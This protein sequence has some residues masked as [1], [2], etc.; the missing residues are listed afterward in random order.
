MHYELQS[1]LYLCCNLLELL[2]RK[3]QL[4]TTE[5]GISLALHGN[6][7]D[8]GVSHF[9][10]QHHLSHFL[11]RECLLDGNSYTLGKLLISSEL[12]ISKT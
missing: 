11:A 8:V 3:L 2:L 9:K 5:I 4:L 12:V 1:S 7:M 10:T 6:E